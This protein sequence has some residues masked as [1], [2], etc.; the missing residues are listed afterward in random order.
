MRWRWRR[1]Q[2]CILLLYL[3]FFFGSISLGMRKVGFHLNRGHTPHFV[4]WGNSTLNWM[5]LL[6]FRNST[7][8]RRRWPASLT[9]AVCCCRSWPSEAH[10][11][12]L[13]VFLFFVVTAPP[14]FSYRFSVSHNNSTSLSI[15]QNY[16]TITCDR[17]LTPFC[18]EMVGLKT[19]F[20][21]SAV[22]LVLCFWLLRHEN[23][24]LVQNGATNKT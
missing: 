18:S 23:A 13:S 11:Y 5:F 12:H 14:V 6:L 2:S 9:V 19:D 17:W 1:Y 8:R 4:G 15:N 16:N 21:C 22:W 10:S 24:F 7:Y 20:P 3:F